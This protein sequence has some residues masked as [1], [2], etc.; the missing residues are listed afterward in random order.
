MG[1]QEKKPRDERIWKVCV[2]YRVEDEVH[3]VTHDIAEKLTLSG[4]VEAEQLWVVA[5]SSL[6]SC[7]ARTRNQETVEARLD[8]LLL[9]Q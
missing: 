7:S 8:G 4:P 9:Q 2:K 3:V 5:L 1:G 6:W